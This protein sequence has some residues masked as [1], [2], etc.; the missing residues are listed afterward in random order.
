MFN[1]AESTYSKLTLFMMAISI[2]ISGCGKDNY[3]GSWSGEID[4]SS[5]NIYRGRKIILSFEENLNY[6]IRVKGVGTERGKYSV[7]GDV[8]SFYVNGVDKGK[9]T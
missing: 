1:N 7:A 2:I 3:I 4:T 8:V 6:S 9:C 5:T